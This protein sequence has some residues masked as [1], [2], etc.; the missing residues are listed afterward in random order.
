MRTLLYPITLLWTFLLG[1]CTSASYP[2][3]PTVAAV[4][5][6]RYSG[7]WIEIAR[8]ENRFE[9]GC[10]SASAEYRLS[11]EYVSVTNRCY[12]ASGQQTAQAFGRAYPVPESSNAKLEVT[13]FRPFYGDYWILML[14]PDYRYS[15]VGDPKRKYL[16]ILSRTPA[17]AADDRAAILQRLPELGYDPAK[18]Y[19]T[20][21]FP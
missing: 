8:Y 1:G 4:D 14:A 15:V 18:L 7:E 16:W 5:L 21:P 10:A 2:P 17:L 12:D 19:W 9:R 3:L 20:R 13:F 6:E 11:H